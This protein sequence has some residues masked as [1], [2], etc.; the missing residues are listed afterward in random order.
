MT[1]GPRGDESKNVAETQEE[2]ME[3]AKALIDKVRGSSASRLDE[4]IMNVKNPQTA[5][6]ATSSIEGQANGAGN[7]G[8]SKEDKMARAQALIAK[9]RGGGE[10]D[11]DGQP[12]KTSTGIGGTWS[13][14]RHCVYTHRHT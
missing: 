7:T 13:P 12:P 9:V 14:S 1:S 5:A 3:R 6:N 4:A 8:E 11:D 2:K 10:K